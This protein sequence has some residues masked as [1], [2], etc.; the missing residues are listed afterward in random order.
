MRAPF[1]ACVLLVLGAV[2]T[3]VFVRTP[4]PA[5]APGSTAPVVGDSPPQGV[6]D[7]VIRD[8]ARVAGSGARV[9]DRAWHGLLH[10]DP[11][12]SPIADCEYWL[13]VDAT[14]IA[15]PEAARIRRSTAAGEWFVTPEEAQHGYRFFVVEP[16]P[17]CTVVQE[18]PGI[19]A[20]GEEPPT[21]V[22]PLA[23]VSFRCLG[24]PAR[25][26]WRVH[27]YPLE[28]PAG[29]QQLQ[30]TSTL[31]VSRGLPPLQ[32][33]LRHWGTEVRHGAATLELVAIAGMSMEVA[34]SAPGFELDRPMQRSTLP[35]AF[36]AN[37]NRV[38]RG[39]HLAMDAHAEPGEGDAVFVVEDGVQRRFGRIE[40]GQG[41]V[42]TEG[43]GEEL[44]V[45]VR[46]SDG[47][48][49]ALRVATADAER[50]TLVSI[51]GS[52][53]T[54]ALRLYSDLRL[55]GLLTEFDDD[56][57]VRHVVDAGFR[58][59]DANVLVTLAEGAQAA[60]YVVGTVRRRIAVG[61]DGRAGYVDDAGSVAWGRFERRAVQPD[62]L[63]QLPAGTTQVHLVVSVG[64]VGVSALG[65]GAWLDLPGVQVAPD[66]AIGVVVTPQLGVTRL[67][68]SAVT[69]SG[70]VPLPSRVLD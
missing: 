21:I 50:R 44:L 49:A 59:A 62:A 11:H 2:L 3:L 29:P 6:V 10:R 1:F 42:A 53:F 16:H 47:A 70:L 60:T 57:I 20:A 35:A 51:P 48:K 27:T 64:L 22:V 39:F 43:L 58:Q 14:A 19:P 4:P 37:A 45:S 7:D 31:M 36:V 41:F 66:R 46:R 68:G 5:V 38:L 28:S 23:T 26:S 24:L 18:L 9:G 65:G 40:G 17:V 54:A 32:V 56:S 52:S 30:T 34:F 15:R 61:E 8:V 55:V 63:W 25:A 13:A 33:F 67:D 69:G 12:G